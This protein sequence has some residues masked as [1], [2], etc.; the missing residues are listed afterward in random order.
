VLAE[1][2]EALATLSKEILLKLLVEDGSHAFERERVLIALGK[3]LDAR[4]LNRFYHSNS[5]SMTAADLLTVGFFDQWARALLA[6]VEAL[7]SAAPAALGEVILYSIAKL[8]AVCDVDVATVRRWLCGRAKD[9]TR[10][11]GKKGR[12]GQLI[13]L[14]AYY[15]TSEA[16]IPWPALLACERGEPFDLATLPAP[17]LAAPEAVRPAALPQ[18]EDHDPKLLRL[19]SRCCFLY[20]CFSCLIDFWRRVVRGS[21]R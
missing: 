21:H 5:F 12:N 19:A 16:R 8:A 9:G 17:V 14:Q 1:G 6:R 18:L 15:F 3:V 4:I 13:C 11:G 7:P 20:I 10:S 2:V